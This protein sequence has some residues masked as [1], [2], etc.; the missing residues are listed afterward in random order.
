MMP[1]LKLLPRALID[2]ALFELVLLRLSG[3]HS[4]TGRM[5]GGTFPNALIGRMNINLS[6]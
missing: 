5:T 1:S 3:L 6:T 2:D 4:L